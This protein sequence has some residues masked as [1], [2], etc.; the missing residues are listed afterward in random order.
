MSFIVECHN[1]Y[2][3]LKKLSAVYFYAWCVSF[4]IKIEKALTAI[5]VQTAKLDFRDFE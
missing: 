5:N 4:E 3:S 2:E 1:K